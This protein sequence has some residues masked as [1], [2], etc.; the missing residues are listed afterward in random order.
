M[1]NSDTSYLVVVV[2]TRGG[3]G[4]ATDIIYQCTDKDE[5]I[6][7]CA[8]Y[9]YAQCDKAVNLDSPY[10]TAHPRIGA[11]DTTH[12]CSIFVSVPGADT[13]NYEVREINGIT[14]RNRKQPWK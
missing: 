4:R 1:S 2:E 14:G 11:S 7:V 10:S 8:D 12:V 3:Y 9:A 5:A 13:K 6:C